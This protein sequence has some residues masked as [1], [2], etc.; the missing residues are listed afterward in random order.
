[1]VVSLNTI[2]KQAYI[3]PGMQTR[4]IIKQASVCLEHTRKL[5]NSQVQVCTSAPDSSNQNTT[6]NRDNS[7]WTI[8]Q[9]KYKTRSQNVI[10]WNFYVCHTLCCY[11][12]TSIYMS[13][14][15]MMKLNTHNTST[16]YNKSLCYKTL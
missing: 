11:C 13:A 14:I 10:I 12:F 1:M 3:K 16:L 9:N 8:L 15:F 4:I 7:N 5:L 2:L 6:I